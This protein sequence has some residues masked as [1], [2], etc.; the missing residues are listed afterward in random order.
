M[1]VAGSVCYQLCHQ[2]VE[3]SKT[4]AG[5]FSEHSVVSPA[6]LAEPTE[7]SFGLRTLGGPTEPRITLGSRSLMESSNFEGRRG[8]PW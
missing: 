8:D 1:G 7:M 5:V 6:K 2:T 3:M 4:E